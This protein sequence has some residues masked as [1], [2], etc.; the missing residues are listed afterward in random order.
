MEAGL[1]PSGKG[2]KYEPPIIMTIQPTPRFFELA[3]VNPLLFPSPRQQRGL[4]FFF[5][6]GRSTVRLGLYPGSGS[7]AFGRYPADASPPPSEPHLYDSEIT[8]T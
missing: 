8:S 5:S 2:L 1:D 3:G 4:L 6:R 7:G